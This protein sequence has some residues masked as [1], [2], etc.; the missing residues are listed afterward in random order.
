MFANKLKKIAMHFLQNDT[1]VSFLVDSQRWNRES[2]ENSEK[3][4]QVE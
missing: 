1:G 3:Y 2:R 4:C